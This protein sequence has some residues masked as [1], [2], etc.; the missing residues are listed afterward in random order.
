MM[1]IKPIILMLA[2][3]IGASLLLPSCGGD[4]NGSDAIVLDGLWEITEIE[5]LT[6]EEETTPDANEEGENTEGEGEGEGESGAGSPP[7]KAGTEGQEESNEVLDFIRFDMTTYAYFTVEG[8]TVS[9]QSAGTYILAGKTLTL[10]PEGE[11]DLP[12]IAI[13]D[14]K[15]NLLTME[16]TLEEQPQIWHAQKMAEDPYKDE[17]GYID[18]ESEVHKPD[19]VAGS[20]WNPDVIVLDETITGTLDTLISLETY[21]A[22]QFY[23]LKVDTAKTYQLTVDV[24]QPTYN[25]P[26]DLVEYV[27]VW[28]SYRPFENNYIAEDKRIKS[29]IET[30]GGLKSP[31]GFLYIRLF[32]YQNKIDFKLKLSEQVEEQ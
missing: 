24:F 9:T 32:S 26:V 12:V 2:V 4:D 13:I 17:E 3:I 16:L 25:L 22:E 5:I 6:I 7:A 14:L 23:Y 20:V 11:T 31:T 21:T 18:F 19:S 1:K 27:Q 10:T 15:S 29:G 30:F 28:L 8:E